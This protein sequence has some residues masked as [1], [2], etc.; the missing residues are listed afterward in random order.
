M[1]KLNIQDI[2]DRILFFREQ[3]KLS[4]KELSLR[5]GKAEDYISKLE[6]RNF[7]LPTFVLLDILNVLDV[8]YN[9]FFSKDYKNYVVNERI[10]NAIENLSGRQRV[11]VLELLESCN[12]WIIKAIIKLKNADANFSMK[13]VFLKYF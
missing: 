9:E 12:K 4:A 2:I 7:N 3:K 5:I 8:D 11:L 6:S 13:N 1:Y 10:M